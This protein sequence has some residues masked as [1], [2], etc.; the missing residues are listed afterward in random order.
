MKRSELEQHGVRNI[1]SDTVSVGG[2]RGEVHLNLRNGGMV[3]E[4]IAFSVDEAV[5]LL[6]HLTYQ[7]AD[8]VEAER[9]SLRYQTEQRVRAEFAARDA[10]EPLPPRP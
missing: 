3:V 8:A 10:G 9:A 4:R 2:Y 5:G 7:L 1:D 6:R